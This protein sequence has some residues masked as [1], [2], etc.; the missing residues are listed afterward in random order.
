MDPL[1]I[2]KLT[3]QIDTFPT[4]PAVVNRV[5][6]ITSDPD[7]TSTDLI[8]VIIPDIALTT[9]II[10][11]ANSA[12]FGLSSQVR[13]LQQAVTVL[14]FIEIRNLVI[15]K[16]IFD[17]FKNFN[18]VLQLDIQKFWEHSFLCGLSS[19]LLASRFS[20]DINEF[21]VAGLI[22]DV[23]KLIINISMP[24]ESMQIIE[25]VGPLKFKTHQIENKILGITHE[26]LGMMI[27]K[28]WM[29]PEN[30]IIS[31]G[32]HHC[33]GKAKTDNIFP[34]IVFTA[35]LL[36]HLMET[37]EDDSEQF[38]QIKESIFPDIINV[39][40][41]HGVEWKTEDLEMLLDDLSAQIE[42]KSETIGLFIS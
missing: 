4:L 7:S 38:N 32:Y 10:K 28:R 21:F 34:S 39:M 35:D 29:F 16:A 13:S 41:S 22:H 42:K 11:V 36:C 17:S 20:K 19:K 5:L 27:L 23:G 30:L 31:A 12:F 40:R 1:H 8:K 33:P 18:N 3:H 14:G 2:Q 26:A 6:K 9:C 37:R 25:N 15:S 24:L